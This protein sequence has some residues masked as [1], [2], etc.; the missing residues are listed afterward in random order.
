MLRIKGDWDTLLRWLESGWDVLYIAHPLIR[1][2]EVTSSVSA[3]SFAWHGD[4]IETLQVARRHD[5]ALRW[6]DVLKLHWSACRNLARRFGGS[7]LRRDFA[8]AGHALA[9]I[10]VVAASLA[11]MLGRRVR[12]TTRKLDRIP[13]MAER[14]PL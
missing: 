2:I 7:L 8:R 6:R 14:S 5:H 10:P 4:L 1:Y 3:G 11:V 12:G 13:F 9:A